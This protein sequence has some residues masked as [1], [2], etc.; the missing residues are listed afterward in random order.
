MTPASVWLSAWW[1][2]GEKA[3]QVQHSACHSPPGA[4]VAEPEPLPSLPFG[5]DTNAPKASGE[6]CEQ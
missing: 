2:V 4:T 6:L 3:Q 1:P 5:M